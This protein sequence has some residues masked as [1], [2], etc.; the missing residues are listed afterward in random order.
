MINVAN[1]L[2]KKEV[3][4]QTLVRFFMAQSSEEGYLYIGYPVFGSEEGLEQVGALLVSPK[5][6]VISFDLRDERKWQD[7][8]IDV[9]DDNYNRLESKFRNNKNLVE[10]R[11]LKFT[12][13]SVV[14][15]PLLNNSDYDNE[16]AVL[17]EKT[18]KE[19][20]RNNEEKL[21]ASLYKQIVSSVQAISSIR[22]NT[23]KRKNASL[24]NSKGKKLEELE[25]SIAVFDKEQNKGMIETVHGV[26]RIRGLAGS[27]KTIVL[28]A[29]AAYLHS[30]EPEWKIAVTFNTRSLKGQFNRLINMFSIEQSRNEPNWDFVQ[31]IHAWGAPT[32]NPYYSQN[33]IYYTYCKL[34]GVEYLDFDSA[35]RKY[36]ANKA[37]EKV[38]EK[39]LVDSKNQPEIEGIYD[40][41]L[42]DEA[43]DLSP[44]FLQICYKLLKAPKRLVYAYDELQ[45]LNKVTMPSPEEI[46][47]KDKDGKPIV[48]FKENNDGEP[49]QDII[50]KCCYRN[51]R[52]VLVTAHAL[53]FGIYRKPQGDETTGI[54]QMFD[55]QNLWRDVGYKCDTEI[56]DGE[57]VILYR[58]DQSSPEFLEN[59]SDIDDLIQFHSFNTKAEQDEWLINEI[60]KDL[61][62]NELSA[63]DIIV[64]NPDPLTTRKVV[65]TIRAGLFEKNINNHLAGVDTSPDVF[66]LEDE[67][68]VFSGIYRAKGNEAG[69]VYI[70]N[71]QDC[72]DDDGN[73]NIAVIR[74]RLFTAITRS[75]AWVRVVGFGPNMKKLE[76]EFNCVKEHRFR[77]EF[78]YPTEEQRKVMNIVNRDMTSAERK[79]VK[80]NK[81]KMADIVSLLENGNLHIEDLGKETIIKLKNL[82]DER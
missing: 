46:F 65:G 38:C 69:L 9:I 5:W 51:S 27:G 52:P 7:N 71:A 73:E 66:Y 54:V 21:D 4:A 6:G 59:H 16:Y 35:K 61:T 81:K 50:L 62:E 47:G 17:N 2:T 79:A 74:N 12:I 13:H 29:K 3:V 32:R 64:I 1:G 15:N 34:Y 23:K 25:N 49:Q 56:K 60:Q 10:K 20:L 57:E 72:Y 58:D 8:Y 82:L 28:A 80:D 41:I 70:I 44:F 22:K 55:R 63:N 68:I 40:V 30:I 26:Q 19:Y 36:G 48:Q 33:G 78:V 45:S 77:L 14:F 18:L 31:I 75:K 67:S 76:Q 11:I 53:G 42:V 43:Q 39:A 24:S 37:F